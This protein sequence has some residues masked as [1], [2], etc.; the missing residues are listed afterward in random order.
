[1]ERLW[2]LIVE[3]ITEIA[4]LISA[5]YVELMEKMLSGNSHLNAL[6]LHEYSAMKRC[7]CTSES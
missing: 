3:V 6:F 5:D 1:M 2:A 4:E 7:L